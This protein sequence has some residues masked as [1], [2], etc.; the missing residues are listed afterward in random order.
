MIRLDVNTKP[1]IALTTKLNGLHR[2][3]FP[4]AVR[5]SL[6]E[7][8]FDAKKNVPLVASQNFTIRQKNLFNR[9]TVVEKA[10]GLNVG[11]MVSRVGLDGTKQKKLTEG[12]VKQETGGTILGR[13]LIA[14]DMARTSSSPNKKVKTKNYLSKITNI[15][16][17]GNRKRGS[18][19]FTIKKGNK[20]TVFERL[21]KSKFVPIYNKRQTR[22]SRVQ[23]KPFIAPSALKASANMDIIYRKQAEY[24]FSKYL[25]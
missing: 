8:A 4:S 25:K 16:T 23:A 15:G 1:L 6:N 20:A 11:N 7:V 18:K 12:L 14:N 17:P 10:K 3:A 13:K 9:F 24:Q 19:Y 21:S 2:S 22:N 5:N